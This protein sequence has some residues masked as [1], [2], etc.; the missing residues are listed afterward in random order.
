MHYAPPP[1]STKGVGVSLQHYTSTN[2]CGAKE[3]LEP[4]DK[5]LKYDFNYQVLNN[6]G[7][8]SG[9]ELYKLKKILS[10]LTYKLEILL[11]ERK[12]LIRNQDTMYSHDQWNK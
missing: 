1:A 10:T 4:I 12:A 2:E 8:V 6:Y 9:A 7:I 3:E 5:N 11:N